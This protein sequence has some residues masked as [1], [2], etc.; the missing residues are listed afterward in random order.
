MY[1]VQSSN[2]VSAQEAH[3]WPAKHGGLIIEGM[4]LSSQARRS[5]K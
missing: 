5:K 3:Y 2:E 1:N 4:L